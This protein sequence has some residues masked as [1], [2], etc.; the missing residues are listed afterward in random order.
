MQQFFDSH[1]H[2][3]LHSK[4]RQAA[5]GVLHHRTLTDSSDFCHVSTQEGIARSEGAFKAGV[6]ARQC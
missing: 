3:A 4:A 5:A 1:N 2:A 6:C